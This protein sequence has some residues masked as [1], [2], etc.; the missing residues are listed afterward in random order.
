M[1]ELYESKSEEIEKLKGLS[2]DTI[3][4]IKEKLSTVF[5]KTKEEISEIE[6]ENK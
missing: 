1:E 6:K 2:K 3:D 5:N 4:T